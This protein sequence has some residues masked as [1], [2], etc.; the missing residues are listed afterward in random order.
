MIDFSDAKIAIFPHSHT[1]STLFFFAR[2]QQYA[3]WN[4]EKTNKTLFLIAISVKTHTFVSDFYN[5]VATSFSGSNKSLGFDS[6]W[7]YTIH[8]VSLVGRIS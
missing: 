8:G 4:S 3:V 2:A 7:S 6:R 1:N 5:N